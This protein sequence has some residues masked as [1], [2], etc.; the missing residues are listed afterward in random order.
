MK[1]LQRDNPWLVCLLPFVVFMLIGSLEPSPP[2]ADGAAAGDAAA[3]AKPW[4]DLGIEYRHYPLIYTIKI[5]LTVAT[6]IFVWPGY[7]QYLWR[8]TP[9]GLA[10]G[11][12]GAVAWI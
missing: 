8:F 1:S 4:L 9:L 2:S 12:L 6:M 7:R 3:A 10:V 5:A 11:V